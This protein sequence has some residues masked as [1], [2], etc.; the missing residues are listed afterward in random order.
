MTI[1]DCFLILSFT[2]DWRSKKKFHFLN[3]ISE[4]LLGIIFKFHCVPLPYLGARLAINRSS[5]VDYN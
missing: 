4:C 3:D 2:D 5:P 1:L